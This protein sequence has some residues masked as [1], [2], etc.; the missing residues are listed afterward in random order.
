MASIEAKLVIRNLRF[1]DFLFQWIRFQ[2]TILRND[3]APHFGAFPKNDSDERGGHND[4]FQCEHRQHVERSYGR[5]HWAIYQ[6]VFL[7]SE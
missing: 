3:L 7:K 1:Y 4:G 5:H 6:Q 2:S